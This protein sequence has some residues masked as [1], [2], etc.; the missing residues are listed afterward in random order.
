MATQPIRRA[1]GQTSDEMA[2]QMVGVQ[3]SNRLYDSTPR[4]G[5][6]KEVSD[7]LKAEAL[8]A[9]VDQQMALLRRVRERGRVNL[10]DL[11][12]V[13]LTADNYM[14]SCKQ[15]GIFPT[16][17]GFSAAC[18]YSR[19]RVYEYLDGHDNQTSQYIDALR[20]SWAAILASMGLARQASE[21][22]AIFLLK[23]SGQG[24]SDRVEIAPI[25]APEPPLGAEI[26]AEEIAKKYEL[27]PD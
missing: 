14:R 12:E 11:D 5:T 8:G 16:M 9:A 23:N 4:R 17:L 19:K 26:T 7:Q 27:L 2:A 21:A 22:V 10:N 6:Y 24:M 15:A 20:T 18:G 3:D 1:A 13:E 25:Q